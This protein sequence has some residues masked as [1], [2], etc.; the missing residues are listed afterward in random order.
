[1]SW[2]RQIHLQKTN[3]VYS[4]KNMWWLLHRFP[5]LFL[6]TPVA[7][8]RQEGP[9]QA[10]VCKCKEG[11]LPWELTV[12]R[13]SPRSLQGDYKSTICFPAI[14]SHCLPFYVYSLVKEECEFWKY[15]MCSTSLSF[16]NARTDMRMHSFVQP[17]IKQIRNTNLCSKSSLL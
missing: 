2:N 12:S 10:K 3:N 5:T 6:I 8:D 7:S 1:M 15:L 11:V 4:R 17:N 16:S 13:K 14:L 9:I